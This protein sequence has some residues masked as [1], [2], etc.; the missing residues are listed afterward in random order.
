MMNADQDGGNAG[1]V[2][3]GVGSAV[4]VPPD[5]TRTH[6]LF[7]RA[8][9]K[10]TPRIASLSLRHAKPC[11]VPRRSA[12][13]VVKALA[14]ESARDHLGDCDD[15]AVP[16]PD[17]RPL[18]KPAPRHQNQTSKPKLDENMITAKHQE[19]V[20]V[21]ANSVGSGGL[22]KRG[23]TPDEAGGG[24]VASAEISRSRSL[25]RLLRARDLWRSGRRVRRHVMPSQASRM[26]IRTKRSNL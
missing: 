12:P 23:P 26:S 25:T 21:A 22:D 20:R 15:R 10:M 5:G 3:I 14:R 11:P 24:R 1:R 18:T 17:A 2:I 9:S 4:P 13:S 6:Q 16:E 7:S 8:T 19:P